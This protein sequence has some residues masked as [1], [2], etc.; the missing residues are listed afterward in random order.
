[1]SLE[2]TP[3]A[4]PARSGPAISKDMAPQ[5]ASLNTAST[6]QS[7]RDIA[8]ERM[9][10]VP[11]HRKVSPTPPRNNASSKAVAPPWPSQSSSALPALSSAF[12]E[13]KEFNFTINEECTAL[14]L[15][16]TGRLLVAGF[17]DGTVR[18][19][20][21]T[22]RYKHKPAHQKPSRSSLVLS[23]LHQQYGAVACQIISK[24]VHTSLLMDVDVS[25]DSLWAF[26]GV[27]RGSM[28][29]CAIH[30]GHLEASYDDD[31][32]ENASLLD[33]LTVFR[34]ADAKLRGF[35]ACTRLH[36]QNK[37]LLFTGKA[38]KNI[39]VW[40]FE[41]PS[42]PG[43]QPVWQQLYDTQTNG[44][45]I[46]HLSFRHHPSG[47]LLGL[48]KSDGQKLRVWD[49][50]YEE[51]VVGNNSPSR[52]NRPT[53]PPF[54][55]PAN[56][57]GMLGVAGGFCLCGG[58][59]ESMYNQMSIVSLDVENLQSPYNHTE[60][61]LPGTSIPDT[62]SSRSRRNRR[63]QRGDLKSVESVAGMLTDAGQALLELSDG[64]LVQYT[65]NEVG[66][67]QLRALDIDRYGVQEVPEGWGRCVGVG[68][69]AS[70]GL[71]VAAV[72]VYN[73]SIGKGNITVWPLDKVEEKIKT[74]HRGFWGFFAPPLLH[75]AGFGESRSTV[76]ETNNDEDHDTNDEPV[77]QAITNSIYPKTCLVDKKTKGNKRESLQHGLGSKRP[78]AGTAEGNLHQQSIVTPMITS[79]PTDPF[80]LPVARRLESTT[81][82][83]TI[84]TKLSKASDKDRESEPTK[85]RKLPDGRKIST[86]FDPS[87]PV[88][89][90]KKTK[91]SAM[92]T[93]SA[94]KTSK[95][96]SK[97]ASIGR[98]KMPSPPIPRKQ[99]SSSNSGHLDKKGAESQSP[100]GCKDQAH[101]NLDVARL[102]CELGNQRFNESEMETQS[103][104]TSSKAVLSKS[105]NKVRYPVRSLKSPMGHTKKTDPATQF[106]I[107][108]ACS[109]HMEKL[110]LL[111]KKV[112]KSKR[113]S[114]LSASGMNIRQKMAVEHRAAHERASK[115]ILRVSI[116][117]IKS[118]MRTPTP[119]AL[120]EARSILNRTLQSY[121]ESVGK[122]AKYVMQENVVDLVL[123]SPLTTIALFLSMFFV[124]F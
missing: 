40:S 13:K 6:K 93:P 19:L 69:I 123:H 109:K 92:K 21:L 95:R 94:S 22:G 122:K 49:L 37:Y 45:T 65:Q 98:P 78:V 2:V 111:L 36:N 44:N 47:R 81:P 54:E 61:A 12:Q 46:K 121:R 1:M 83:S 51:E 113:T 67:P 32:P 62:S 96:K 18:L 27:L 30:L 58:S 77:I 23:R 11:P 119:S 9:V 48:S 43:E 74:P 42:G 79:Q 88:L 10:E 56:T 5:S 31:I 41:P 117:A 68:R 84:A 60:L 59:R 75:T 112:S 25:Q 29:L 55:D 100:R 7:S 124:L 118:V 26:A 80:S 4:F 105:P 73:P 24:G 20:D 35:G 28:E 114:R 71:A 53:R 116:S 64:S 97:T 99:S 87:E 16:P 66:L 57:E 52:H 72:S 107:R 76:K 14:K 110:Q 3:K 120:N 89:S 17:S 50:S 33:H 63:E 15:S 102:L 108:E 106:H 34:H 101:S 115:S 8:P 91:T 103:K 104:T 86:A 39:H 90:H 85:Y 38:I 70:C 82:L